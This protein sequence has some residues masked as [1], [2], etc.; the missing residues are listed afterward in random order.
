MGVV[1]AFGLETQ[2]SIIFSFNE[3]MVNLPMGIV[4][5]ARVA[6]FLFT[7]GGCGGG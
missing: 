2:G 1:G 6:F 4:F 5:A 3:S 7:L